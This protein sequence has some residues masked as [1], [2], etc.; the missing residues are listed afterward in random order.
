MGTGHIAPTRSSTTTSSSTTEQLRLFVQEDGTDSEFEAMFSDPG[1]G[2]RDGHR[3]AIVYAGDQASQA[4]YPMALVNHST[5]NQRVFKERAG[6]IVSRLGA[7]L[8]CA[9]LVGVAIGGTVLIGANS[10]IPLL[11]VLITGA[12]LFWKYLEKNRL[13]NAIV[14]AVT[15]EASRAA[16]SQRGEPVGNVPSD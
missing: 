5:G 7:G 2:V 8:G 3:V 14:A 6:W 10:S 4:G 1:F 11:L 15:Q 12:W 13:T 9:L 16:D